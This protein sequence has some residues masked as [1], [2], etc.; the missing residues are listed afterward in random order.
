MKIALENS[1]SLSLGPDFSSTAS[2]NHRNPPGIFVLHQRGLRRCRACAPVLLRGR[3]HAERRRGWEAAVPAAP[4]SRDLLHPPPPGALA[5]PV[6]PTQN[7]PS[8]G[9][10]GCLP[11]QRG[12]A[13][14][15]EAGGSPRPGHMGLAAGGGR[16]RQKEQVW[17]RK[18]TKRLLRKRQSWNFRTLLLQLFC[19]F[20]TGGG[21]L[22]RVSA[23]EGW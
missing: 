14:H 4:R 17:K 22:L 11:S 7:N 12:S 16:G 5:S 20:N 23:V 15:G 9:G 18:G 10:T 3:R 21:A 6:P 1:C 8:D 13:G 2:P 19:S